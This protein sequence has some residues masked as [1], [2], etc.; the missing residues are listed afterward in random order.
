MEN[1]FKNGSSDYGDESFLPDKQPEVKKSKNALLAILLI[2][3]LAFFFMFSA[4]I[5]DWGVNRGGFEDLSGLFSSQKKEIVEKKEVIIEKD[6][7]EY[8]EYMDT[9]GSE[10]E[11]D[12]LVYEE[13]MNEEPVVIE[14]P[15]PKVK[16]SEPPSPKEP[17]EPKEVA[18]KQSQDSKV[19]LDKVPYPE[20][21]TNRMKKS[22]VNVADQIFTIQIYSTPSQDDAEAWKT[23]LLNQNISD[24]VVTVQKIRNRD[25]YR[26]RF[27]TFKS[28]DE[29]KVAAMKFGF[30]HSWI[31][32][33]K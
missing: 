17:K 27:G 31:D 21:I 6:L 30:A 5:Y 9:A 24:V 29:A 23:K 28:Y 32:R 26:V 22:N 3:G 11:D 8:E 15:L 12:N 10:V 25:W 16:S 1:N 7:P 18:A 33:V 20:N 19:D 4:L 14:K 13:K 2:A